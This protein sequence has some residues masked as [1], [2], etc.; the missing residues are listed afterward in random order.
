MVASIIENRR[1]IGAE[2]K[3]DY[4][5]IAKS[6]INEAIVGTIKIRDDVPVSIPNKNSGV[7]KLPKEFKI[8]RSEESVS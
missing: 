3:N 1:F 7:A 4:F 2:I 8:A 5:D 6:R